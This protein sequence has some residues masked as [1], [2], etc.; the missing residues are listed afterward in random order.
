[1]LHAEKEAVVEE[2]EAVGAQPQEQEWVVGMQTG[3]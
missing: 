2:A 3:T 1:M